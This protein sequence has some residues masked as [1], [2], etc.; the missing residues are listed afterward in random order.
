MRTVLL[1]AAALLAIASSSPTLAQNACAE[2]YGSCVSVCAS[3]PGSGQNRCM[4]SC[5]MRSNQCYEQAWGGRPQTVITGQRPNPANPP[6]E[7]LATG[8]KAP[9]ARPQAPAQQQQQQQQQQQPQPQP[10]QQ[11]R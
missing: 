2:V 1:A 5:Q 8:D 10:Q 9:V 3:K 11:P 7:A 6:A 4:E